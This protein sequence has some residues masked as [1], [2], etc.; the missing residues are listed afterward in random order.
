MQWEKDNVDLD[1]E[2]DVYG[3]GDFEESPNI[4]IGYVENFYSGRDGIRNDW[5]ASELR[6]EWGE[7]KEKG[8]LRKMKNIKK[9]AWSIFNQIGND[10]GVTNDS[11]FE[12]MSYMEFDEDGM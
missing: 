8:I 2:N 7:S 11:C 5:F 3:N 12:E 10:G 6:S 1:L 9:Q 4:R